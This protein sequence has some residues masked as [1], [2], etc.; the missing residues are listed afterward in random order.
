MTSKIS[1]KRP[2]LIRIVDS[3]I[4]DRSHFEIN[5]RIRDAH[6]RMYTRYPNKK[7]QSTMQITLTYIKQRCDNIQQL[8]RWTIAPISRRTCP[9]RPSIDYYAFLNLVAPFYINIISRISLFLSLSLGQAEQIS[10]DSRKRWRRR[11]RYWS[12][13]NVC[14]INAIRMGEAFKGPSY[15]FRDRKRLLAHRG[16]IP[17]EASL[18]DRCFSQASPLSLFL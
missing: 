16:I 10:G 4:V 12:A 3:Y 7:Q 18:V 1:E 14:N 11:V 8:S 13:S 15:R 5:C 6:T 2:S 9:R 17:E